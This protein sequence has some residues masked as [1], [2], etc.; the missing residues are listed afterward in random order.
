VY[1]LACYKHLSI[2][3]H[4][5]SYTYFIR[6]NHILLNNLS[7]ILATATAINRLSVIID[8][9][10]TITKIDGASDTMPTADCSFVLRKKSFLSL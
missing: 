5:S 2:E 4:S 9:K 3:Q 1:V 8:A 7:F 6:A 10:I